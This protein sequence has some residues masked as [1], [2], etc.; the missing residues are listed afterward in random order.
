M[1]GDARHTRLVTPM[2]PELIEAIDA[3]IAAQPDPKPRRPEAIRRLIQL[4]IQAS[5]PRNPA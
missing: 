3:W 4:G 1:S 2:P 5:I